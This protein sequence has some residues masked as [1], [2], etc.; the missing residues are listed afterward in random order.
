MHRWLLG[1]LCLSTVVPVLALVGSS[2]AADWPQWQGPDRTGVSK[3]TGLLK[4][5]PKDGP[6]LVWTAR[7]VGGGYCTPSV[8]GGKVFGMGFRDGDEVAWAL[9]EKTGKEV[10]ST[11]IAASAKGFGYPEGSRGTPTVDGGRLYT[12]GVD[13]DLVCLEAEGGKEVWHKNLKKDFGGG[14]PGWG[15]C[16]SPLIDGDK[17]ICTPGGKNTIVALDKKT[18]DVVW[19]A[20]V[21]QGNG[22]HYS[23]AVVAEIGSQRQYVQFLSGGVVGVAAADGKVLWRYDAP[24]NG[25]ANCSTPV[26]R[27]GF[28]FAA[29]AYGKGGGL[30]H[31]LTTSEKSEAKEVYFDKDMQNHHGGMVLV[32]GYLYGEGSGRLRCLN[33]S[34][35]E[36]AWESPKPGKG[37]VTYADGS[38][39]YQNEGGPVVLVEATPK[40]YVEKGRFVPPDRS[41]KNA[42][43]HP[44]IA[45]GKLYLR[46]Q[47]VLHCYDVKQK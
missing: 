9:D 1:S 5:W 15:Y 36:V 42:W 8:A 18:G 43:P 25:T 11:K 22:A 37:S 32:D 21:P 7:G 17:L 28:V 3:E 2:S 34:T 40:Q 19:K 27:D 45:N 13:G 30:A 16:E 41:K 31:V 24:A 39:F 38:L 4:V 10:W 23:S 26:V 44:V 14:R 33:F 20:S 29:S 47:D 12:L 35:G 6:P 46:D